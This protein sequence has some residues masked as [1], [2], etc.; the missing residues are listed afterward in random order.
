M[1]RR[2]TLILTFA[3]LLLIG[4]D[5]EAAQPT[6]AATAGLFVEAL[7]AGDAG[8]LE[9]VVLDK[10]EPLAAALAPNLA[11]QIRLHEAF[12]AAF[13]EGHEDEPTA[14]LALATRQVT[15]AAPQVDGGQ[16]VMPIDGLPGSVKFVLD[17]DE[18]EIDLA[19]TL[20]LTNAE[21]VTRYVDTMRRLTPVY[22]DVAAR[23]ESGEL[24]TR[25]AARD[26]LTQ[27]VLRSSLGA[28]GAG[29]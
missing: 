16:A 3:G 25:A 28:V 27:S 20:G 23:V 15:L 10:D 1:P 29:G 19:A 17:G 11:A 26:A 14:L 9:D 6:P 7:A 22:A 18:W 4:C 13:G 12:V 21:A 2:L 24:T 8:A 5:G